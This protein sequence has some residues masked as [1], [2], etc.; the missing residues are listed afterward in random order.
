MLAVAESGATVVPASP[1]FYHRPTRV[2]ELVDF[3]VQR[4][5]DQVGLELEIAPRWGETSR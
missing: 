5:L 3:V 2:D 4:V 1:G